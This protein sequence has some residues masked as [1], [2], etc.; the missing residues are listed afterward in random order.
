MTVFQQ[1]REMFETQ[2]MC[3][4]GGDDDDDAAKRWV[5][6]KQKRLEELK[7]IERRLEKE[8]DDIWKEAKDATENFK[9]IRDKICF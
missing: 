4:D 5:K 1:K 3:V 2:K 9:R 6:V 7:E 8:V